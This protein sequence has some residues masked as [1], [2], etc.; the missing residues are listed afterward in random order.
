MSDVPAKFVAGPR[1]FEVTV[2]KT[3]DGFKAN[4]PILGNRDITEDKASKYWNKYDCEV[5]DK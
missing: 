5:I 2:W 1:W 3:A 4:I